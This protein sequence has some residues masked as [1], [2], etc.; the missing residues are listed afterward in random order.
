MCACTPKKTKNTKWIL[1]AKNTKW[2]A[3]LKK[4]LNGIKQC[5][6]ERVTKSWAISIEGRDVLTVLLTHFNP[7]KWS[8]YVLSCP[9]SKPVLLFPHC[10]WAI[11]AKR[12]IVC[13]K[14]PKY[15]FLSREMLVYTTEPLHYNS[16]PLQPFRFTLLSFQFQNLPPKI[17]ERSD[18][19]LVA[20]GH[21]VKHETALG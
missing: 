10:R 9:Y 1:R 11:E 7:W 2:K 4:Q 8:P 14:P 6:N 20:P 5:E 12:K 17:F 3:H 16:C 15:L 19:T 21:T 18:C 13:L